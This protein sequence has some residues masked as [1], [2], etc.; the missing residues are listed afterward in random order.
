MVGPL[1][2]QARIGLKNWNYFVWS[3]GKVWAYEGRWWF[4]VIC[5]ALGGCPIE[6]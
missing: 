4:G 6:E 1:R 3:R 5:S 2:T